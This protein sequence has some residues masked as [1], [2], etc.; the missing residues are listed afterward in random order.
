DRRVR[1]EIVAGDSKAANHSS[2]NEPRDGE[3]RRAA[4]CSN[5]SLSF[6]HMS[7][8]AACVTQRL[9]STHHRLSKRLLACSCTALDARNPLGAPIHIDPELAAPVASIFSQVNAHSTPLDEGIELHRSLLNALLLSAMTVW[10]I[11]RYCQA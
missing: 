9:Q 8:A 2:P 3:S 7:C 4:T 1:G 11:D 5:A 10:Q 6:C